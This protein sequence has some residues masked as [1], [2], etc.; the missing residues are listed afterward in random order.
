[1]NELQIS[2]TTVGLTIGI[3]TYG[4]I[5]SHVIRHK[6]GEYKINGR[7]KKDIVFDIVIAV[8]FGIVALLLGIYYDLGVVLTI[9]LVAI[10]SYFNGAMYRVLEDHGP[11][12]V[13]LLGVA[14]R[15]KLRSKLEK[16]SGATLTNSKST[17]NPDG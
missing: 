6:M 10:V 3:A 9:I 7:W 8:F 15:A 4:A 13:S 5:T 1:M 11:P 16:W 14:I 2:L 12:A 17:D